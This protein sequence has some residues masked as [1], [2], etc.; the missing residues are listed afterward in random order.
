MD[1][2]E[3]LLLL[4]L[5]VQQ[6]ADRADAAPIVLDAGDGFTAVVAP[7]YGGVISSIRFSGLDEDLLW[8]R[9]DPKRLPSLPDQH[10][11]AGHESAVEFDTRIF[12]GGWFLMF[13]TAGQPAEDTYQH[14]WSGRV[15]WQVDAIRPHSVR[16][17][18]TGA[19]GNG[20]LSRVSRSIQLSREGEMQSVIVSTLVE[21]IGESDGVFTAGEHPCFRRAVFAGGE[22]LLGAEKPEPIV[23]RIPVTA[24]G[25]SRHNTAELL[26]DVVIA[27]PLH[28]ARL[29]HWQ[30][31]AYPHGTLWQN[32]S[33]T[34]LPDA[35]VVAW[36]CASAPG[37]R[38]QDARD[39]DA[40]IVLE[41]GGT[42]SFEARLDWSQ[43]S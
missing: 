42:C 38:Y 11:V 13:P 31:A 10:A 4:R 21:N 22:A 16:L 2:G 37:V 14:G 25:R 20:G 43:V 40:E 39:A 32:Y 23:V 17:S 9:G 41:P 5:L 35:D 12:L 24:D 33:S 36:E 3:E 30:S 7:H 15:P 28:G 1:R 8:V 18:A 27:A 26:T 34:A 6:V 29:R 19:F